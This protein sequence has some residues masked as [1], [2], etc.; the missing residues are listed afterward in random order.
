MS[1]K[2]NT[3]ADVNV[4]LCECMGVYG[5]HS[6]Q[7]IVQ[8]HSTESREY[9]VSLLAGV[10][11]TCTQI[12][13]QMT[14]A[15]ISCPQVAHPMPAQNN[16]SKCAPSLS[17]TYPPPCLVVGLKLARRPERDPCYSEWAG[18]IGC[19]GSCVMYA[20]AYLTDRGHKTHRRRRK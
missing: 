16:T 19:Q 18:G 2:P 17:P 5:L 7:S 15:L 9:T 8:Y 12:H 13:R 6:S 10:V 11:V 4:C 20:H 3:W 14:P 1:F